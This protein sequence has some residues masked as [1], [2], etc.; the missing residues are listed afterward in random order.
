MRWKRWKVG[1]VKKKIEKI[2]TKIEDTRMIMQW[3][4]YL[5][6]VFTAPQFYPDM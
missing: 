3:E 2:K 4:P 1:L 6:A 5:A